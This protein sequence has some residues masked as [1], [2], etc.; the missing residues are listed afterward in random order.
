LIVATLCFSF[1]LILLYFT[2]EFLVK[3]SS[4]LALSFNLRPLVIGMTVVAFATSMPELM[5][6]LAAVVKQSSALAAGNIIGSNIANIGLILGVA[7][8]LAPINISR[9]V[10]VR[11]IPI[12]LLASGVVYLM[13]LDGQ[14]G[15]FDGGL[16][17]T[18]LSFFLGYCIRTSRSNSIPEAI[19][20]DG[21]EFPS[22][23]GRNIMFVM[24]G[25]IGLGIGAEIMVRSAVFIALQLGIS[26]LIVGVTVVA[27]GTSLPE[28]AASIVSAW[29]G[30]GDMSIGNVI[31][32]NI[33]NLFFVLGGCALVHP[34]HI[35]PGILTH[36]LPLMLVFS[37]ALWLLA[38]RRKQL[39]RLEGGSL[40]AGY[41]GFVCFYLL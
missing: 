8:L 23:S 14:I 37:V 12:M 41:L 6:S 25:I 18:G 24:A 16:L 9:G 30:E 4:N 27:L 33:F 11:E 26:D 20:A 7:A 29:R 17:L 10:L 39:G 2:A 1:G 34:V 13:S 36:E 35:D 28:L 21:K 38:L 5:V 3:G 31:G 40:L 15:R 19:F 32:S 22:T